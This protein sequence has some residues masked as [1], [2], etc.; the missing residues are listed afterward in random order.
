MNPASSQVRAFDRKTGA[1]FRT[2]PDAS[3]VSPA[4][5]PSSAMFCATSW[6]AQQSTSNRTDSTFRNR[7]WR[8]LV[9]S[10]SQCFGTPRPAQYDERRPTILP[11]VPLMNRVYRLP[12]R[13]WKFWISMT[14]KISSKN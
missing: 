7:F 4:T 5:L 2:W 13:S 11:N 9:A 10:S 12:R 8:F 14:C 3:P 1:E 6:V